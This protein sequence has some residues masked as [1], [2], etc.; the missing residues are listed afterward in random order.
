LDNLLD[1]NELRE[2]ISE[3]GEDFK[4]VTEAEVSFA[5]NVMSF[6]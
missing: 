1:K 6:F 5:F 4:D 3:A 2:M